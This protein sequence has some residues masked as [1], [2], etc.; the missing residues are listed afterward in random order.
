MADFDIAT[1]NPNDE[2]EIG[3]RL[4]LKLFDFV[5]KSADGGPVRGIVTPMRK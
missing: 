5:Q 2:I 4:L 3:G 1:N